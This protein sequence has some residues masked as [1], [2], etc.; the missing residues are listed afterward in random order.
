MENIVLLGGT[1][2]WT[3]AVLW[4]VKEEKRNNEQL[5]RLI[6]NILDELAEYDGR[7]AHLE[8]T[9]HVLRFDGATGVVS[10]KGQR[11]GQKKVSS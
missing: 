1:L 9:A 10:G 7:I 2:V 6:H 3:G 11:T 4:V 5:F 8:A